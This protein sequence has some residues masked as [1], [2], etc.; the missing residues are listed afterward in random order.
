MVHLGTEAVYVLLLHDEHI[1]AKKMR[2]TWEHIV[3]S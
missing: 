1:E 2:A 3:L